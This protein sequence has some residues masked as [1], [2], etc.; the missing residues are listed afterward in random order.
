MGK[1]IS[2]NERL[3]AAISRIMQDGKQRENEEIRQLLKEREG[4][5]AGTDY[6]TDHFSGAIGG[7]YRSGVLERVNRGCYRLAAETNEKNGEKTRADGKIVQD[8]G[9]ESGQEDRNDWERLEDVREE[10]RSSLAKEIAFI[11]EKI[12]ELPAPVWSRLSP[13]YL[14]EVGRL[15]EVR[16]GL[17][18]L[19][20]KLE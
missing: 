12:D 9:G 18:K 13:D 10:I 11:G 17:E 5:T 3:K 2:T 15:M 7:L 19:V 20:K 14:D 4:L 1:E 8:S 16:E 6:N